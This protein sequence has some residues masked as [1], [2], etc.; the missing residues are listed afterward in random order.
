MKT[1]HTRK[2][3][4]RCTQPVANRHQSSVTGNS[5]TPLGL[6]PGSAHTKKN[7][8]EYK[9]T[10]TT[11]IL[12][13]LL[14][15]SRLLFRLHRARSIS[16]P[17]DIVLSHDIATVPAPVGTFQRTRDTGTQSMVA[18]CPPARPESSG[19]K[20]LVRCI[21]RCRMLTLHGTLG[22]YLLFTYGKDIPLSNLKFDLK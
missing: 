6:P 20:V 17:K 5:N 14:F 1:L 2:T 4:Y 22:Y 7:V 8:I 19:H 9:V 11:T 15:I 16:S 10:T 21:R 12:T 18:F 3:T 13:K